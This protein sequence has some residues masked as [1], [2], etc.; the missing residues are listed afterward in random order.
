MWGLIPLFWTYGDVFSGGGVCVIYSLL[1]HVCCDTCLP[2]GGQH[3]LP[4]SYPGSAKIKIS[5][6]TDQL[7]GLIHK[8]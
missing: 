3:A 4:P 1:I 5:L 8:T 2:V 7:V 6:C